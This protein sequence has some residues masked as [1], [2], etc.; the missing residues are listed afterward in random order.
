[1][2]KRKISR[3]KFLKNAA[4]GAGG[5]AALSALGWKIFQHKQGIPFED[6]ILVILMMR[7]GNDGLNSIIPYENDVYHRA[8]SRVGISKKEVLKLTDQIGLNPG[9]EAF[10]PLWDEGEISL[11]HHVGHA[12]PNRSHF[13][14]W[15][16]WHSGETEGKQF[17]EGWAGKWL[18]HYAPE[19]PWRAVEMNTSTVSLALR[20]RKVS[21]I[22]LNSLVHLFQVMENP[23]VNQLSELSHPHP[24]TQEV[25]HRLNESLKTGEFLRKVTSFERSVDGYPGTKLGGQLREVADLILAGANTSIYFVSQNG[26][27]THTGQKNWH[28]KLMANFA[29]S[30]AAFRND[31]KKHGKW[32]NIAVLTLSEFGRRVNENAGGGTDHGSGNSLFLIGGDLRSPGLF[33]GLPDLENLVD[34]DLKHKIDF[35]SLYAAALQDW[36]KADPVKVLGD[37]FPVPELFKRT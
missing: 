6:K 18:S 23:I 5:V 10:L 22:G 24:A 3:R 1:M 28:H 26:F 32:K 9:M 21:G 13:R 8:R 15:D 37:S 11:L 36:L 31:M 16:H 4:L 2:E 14:S 30:V 19:E 20:S 29:N 12:H 34:G 35:R 25:Y 33:N 17:A 7:G 27:D